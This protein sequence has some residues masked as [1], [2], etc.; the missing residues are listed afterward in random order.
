[1]LVRLALRNLLRNVRRTVALVVT[2]AMGTG[3]LFVFHGFNNGIMN[4]YR[5]NT[6][7]ARFGHGQIQTRGY[8]ERVYE[9]PWEHWIEHPQ[10]LRGELLA[11]PGVRQVFP[12]VEF[13]ALLSSGRITVSGK[14]QGVDGPEEYKFFNTLNFVAGSNLTSEPKGIVL[15]LGMARGL[16]TGVGDAVT[17]LVRGAQGEMNRAVLKVT[18]IFHTGLK[19]FDDNVFRI[20]LEVASG[21]LQTDRVES[22]ALGL[23][24][25][26]DFPAV[27]AFVRSHHPELE[28]IPFAVLDEVYYQHSVDWLDAQFG[29]I[30]LIIITIVVLGIFNTVSTG[31]LER[32]Q[33]IGT[34]RANGESRYEIL[35]LLGLEGLTLGV[36]GAVLGIAL[37][38]ALDATVLSRGILMPPAPGI[39]RQFLVML[40]FTPLMAATTAALGISAA[41]AATLVAGLRVTRLGIAEA[42]RAW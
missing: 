36:L 6:I 23:A 32:K 7:H 38:A 19:E 5:D 21:L 37:V 41:L 17:V 28:A 22:V 30:Q 15:G 18:G 1:M 40:E 9:R 33:E 11:L 34:L 29:V 25:A 2:V 4:Q 13:P 27:D 39:T 26:E 42:L 24:S 12:R 14:G 31:I 8:G 3:S 16:G 10:A 35:R 20:P